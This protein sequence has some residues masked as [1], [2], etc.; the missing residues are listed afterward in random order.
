MEERT[1]HT[2]ACNQHRV[3][4]GERDTQRK[5]ERMEKWAPKKKE[6]ETKAQNEFLGMVQSLVSAFK[7]P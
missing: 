4:I 2:H 3:V 5:K 6:K 1:S 7:Q